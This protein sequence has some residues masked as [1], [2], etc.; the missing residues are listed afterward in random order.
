M[1]D[2]QSAIIEASKCLAPSPS[3]CDTCPMAGGDSIE[4][5]ISCERERE[6]RARG[7]WPVAGIDEAG[8]GPWAGP[9]VAAAVILDLENIPKGIDDSKKLTPERRA[10]LYEE[11][12]ATACWAV[13]IADVER[14]ERD[15]LH[16]AT[17]WAMREACSGLALSPAYVLVDGKFC[18]P[19]PCE[20]M[21]IVDGDALSLSIAA[22]SIIAK[23]TRDRMMEELARAWPGYGFERHKGYGTPEHRAA[24]TL[25]GPTPHHRR[26]FA[27]VR[28]VLGEEPQEM[29]PALDLL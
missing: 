17:L 3:L 13:G 8:R 15:N 7:L 12:T 11:I 21:A 25:L 27:S 10:A 4:M 18:P 26:R 6:I 14:I 29:L 16:Y 1:T 5:V 22:A 24:L 19:L 9:V 28:A 2:W 23:V 20:A